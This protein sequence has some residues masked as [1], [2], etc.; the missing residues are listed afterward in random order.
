MLLVAL[1]SV[2]TRA[3]NAEYASPLTLAT[4]TLE[5]WPTPVAEHMVATELA[6]VG[7]HDEAL[8]RMRH[9]VE[10]YPRGLY[11]L[12]VELFNHHEYRESLAVLN[13][14]VQRY[15]VSIEA[16]E[17]EVLQ[18]RAL[19]ALGTPDLA[20]SH[21]EA[22]VRMVPGRT[23][24]RGLLADALFQTG[25]YEAAAPQYAAYLRAYPAD[26]AAWTNLGIS[27]GAGGALNEAI[28]DRKSTRLNSSH[29]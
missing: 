29:T 20:V 7:R 4:S 8:Q 11:D 15:P 14:F 10:G 17:A 1:L 16:P 2:R 23:E 28:E 13:R 18:A 24:W 21:Y 9:S 19:V 22:G 26:T 3:R 27:R 5:R 12:G 6:A 25:H